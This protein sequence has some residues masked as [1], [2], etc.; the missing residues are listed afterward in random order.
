MACNTDLV[1][2]E[3]QQHITIKNLQY[4]LRIYISVSK[5]QKN[6]TELK[7]KITKR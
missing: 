5:T 6:M 7:T 3:Q 2:E 1:K 4:K